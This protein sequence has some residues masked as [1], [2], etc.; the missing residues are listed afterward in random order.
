MD[1]FYLICE[2]LAGL[3]V[4]LVGCKL[5]SDNILIFSII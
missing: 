2:L 5:L 1:Y 3:G 4:F